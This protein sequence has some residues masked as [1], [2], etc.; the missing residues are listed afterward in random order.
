MGRPS[1]ASAIDLVRPF[2]GLLICKSYEIFMYLTAQLK[3]QQPTNAHVSLC[4]PAAYSSYAFHRT[5]DQFGSVVTYSRFRHPKL[6]AEKFTESFE[7]LAIRCAK[8]TVCDTKPRATFSPFTFA[9]PPHE[10][11]ARECNFLAFKFEKVWNYTQSEDILACVDGHASFVYSTRGHRCSP[12]QTSGYQ[13]IVALRTPIPEE[14][15]TTVAMHFAARFSAVDGVI[16]SPYMSRDQ[17]IDYPS[18]TVKGQ[19]DFISKAQ[20]GKSYDWLPDYLSHRVTK[21]TPTWC[22]QSQ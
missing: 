4:G 1:I 15:Y 20:F 3:N 16:N 18:C 9:Q 6:T 13:L 21:P 17:R 8:P 22:R 19:R 12:G 5:D 14:Y 2:S 10:Y 11:Q 7:E